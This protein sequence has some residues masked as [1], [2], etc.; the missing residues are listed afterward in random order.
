MK[1][2]IL[3]QY[4]D[5]EPVPKPGDLGRAMRERGHEVQVL[6]GFPNYPSGVLYPGFRLRLVSR[7]ESDGI[8]MIR[9]WELPYHGRSVLG[10][11]AN[12]GSFMLSAVAGA[13]LLRRFDVIY[14]WHPPLTIGV[15]AWLIGRMRRVP[16]VY[17]VQDIWPDAA[18]LSGLMREG[19]LVR[20]M[21]RLEKFVYR[22]AAHLFV[23][24][25]G[26]RANLIGKG[27]A[28]ERVSVMPHWIDEEAVR[29]QPPEVRDEVRRSFGWDHRF[30]VLFAGNI[31]LVQGLDTLIDA[32]A[33]LPAGSRVLFAV[34]G[35]G[36]DLE[37]LRERAQMREATDRIAF[38]GRQPF[39]SMSRLMAAADVLLVHLRRS[40]ASRDVIPTK[41][42]AYLA[43]GRPVV[44]AMEGAAADLVL[45]AGA[46]IAVP[47]QDAA[48]LCAAV[49]KLEG[50][51]EDEREAYGRRGRAWLLA[52]LRKQDVISRYEKALAAVARR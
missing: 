34:A 10:R 28:P 1:V 21:R 14:V 23:V 24:T 50:M 25:E 52:N 31:G 17:D 40:P 11:I 20:W 15:A 29:P 43:A 19:R 22:R 4:F 47:P 18:V 38:L 12:Y 3:S 51:R 6:T 7:E 5:P 9:T 42:L 26:A 8:P 37:R 44:M 32:A 30:V 41:T 49:R 36:S 35:D 48:E 27:V 45:E 33:S 46:G 2:L 16:F 39:D 13:C